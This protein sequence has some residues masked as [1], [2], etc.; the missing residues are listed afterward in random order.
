M[1]TIVKRTYPH[2]VPSWV[3][4]SQPDPQAAQEF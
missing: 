4:T 3:D 1:T 2:G